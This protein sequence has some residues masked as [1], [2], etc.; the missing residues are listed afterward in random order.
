M[1]RRD[2]IKLIGGGAAAWPVGALAQQPERVRLIAILMGLAEDD[3]ETK[4]RLVKGGLM[5]YGTDQVDMFGQTA[6][7]IDRILRGANP[8]DLPVQTPT[9]YETI[10]NLK[11]AKA[12]GLSVSPGLIVAADEVIE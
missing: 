3:P 1:R 2:F 8:A 11:T 10:L 6:S 12:L 7:Y 9:K 4:K 5:S